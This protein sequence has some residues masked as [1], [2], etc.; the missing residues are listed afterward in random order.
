MGSR[1]RPRN[2]IRLVERRPDESI[3]EQLEKLLEDARAGLIAGLLIAVHYGGQE[4]G[5]SGAGSM[6]SDP[7]RG[8]AAAHRLATKLLH[9]NG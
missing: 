1:A 4:Y 2:V 5:Y 7:A 9:H 6:C 8:I 3:V